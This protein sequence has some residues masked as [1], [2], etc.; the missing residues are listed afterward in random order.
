MCELNLYFVQEGT[1]QA[2][3]VRLCKIHSRFGNI[4][5]SAVSESLG[6]VHLDAG[7]FRWSR[8]VR[9]MSVVAVRAALATVD[10]AIEP[11][12]EGERGSLAASL[13][14]ALSKEPRWLLEAFGV[15]PNGTGVGRRIF[16]RSN[17]GLKR[18]GPVAI[19]LASRVRGE[20]VSIFLNG[21]RL[22]LYRD[23]RALLEA[24]ESPGRPRL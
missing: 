16:A 17:P 24:L 5:G 10:P 13:D 8:A 18:V 6:V 14:G 3:R 22:V 23:L 1:K 12:L 15:F 21:V 9:A 7:T 20:E 2:H 4:E 11:R 19:A